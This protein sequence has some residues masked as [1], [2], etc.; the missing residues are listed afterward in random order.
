MIIYDIPKNRKNLFFHI[1]YNDYP[2][3]HTHNKYWEIFLVTKGNLRHMING[4]ERTIQT[5][6]LV[7]VHPSDV[8]S[9][10]NFPNS[11]SN[12][13]C[14]GVNEVFLK[15][16]LEMLNPSTFEFLQNQKIIEF[17]LSF[18]NAHRIIRDGDKILVTRSPEEY[19]IRISFLF[20]DIVREICSQIF[21]NGN[22]SENDK[23]SAPVESLI[24]LM[25]SPNNM[26]KPEKQLM[27]ELH[28]SYSHMNRVFKKEIGE[29]PA[30]Y[31]KRVRF[32]YAEKLLAETNMPLNDIAT[33][34][35][36][37][38]YSHFSSAFKQYAG[39]SPNAY[40]KDKNNYHISVSENN[41]N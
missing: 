2:I 37:E 6:T 16:Y 3:R 18:S 9:I 14:L 24:N 23:L 31:F 39:V 22:N 21:N 25:N 30:S 13:I 15:Q 34:I 7:I 11:E 27:E 40:K 36:Y 4:Q 10:K 5:N 32:A 29:T 12:H 41:K 19:E 8:H 26:C 38:N 17:P 35:G 20:A 1:Q 28:Y 33:A